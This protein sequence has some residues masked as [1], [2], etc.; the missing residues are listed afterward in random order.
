MVDE[1]T[2]LSG[3]D[4][5]APLAPRRVASLVPWVSESL[6]ELALADRLVAVTDDAAFPEGGFPFAERIGPSVL[7]DIERLLE[8][9]PDLV[10]LGPQHSSARRALQ[11][12]GVPVWLAAPH[13]VREAF[14]GLWDWMNAFEGPQMSARVRAIEWTCDWL[15]R[16]AETRPAPARVL[17]LLDRTSGAAAAGGSYAHDLLRVCGGDALF[18][19]FVA[20][21]VEPSEHDVIALQ[22]EVILLA[23]GG[24]V[25][26]TAGD[27][28]ALASLDTPAGRAGRVVLVDY[29]LLTWPGTRVARAFDVLPNLL[30]LN[31]QN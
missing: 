19:G 22:P 23:S 27:A 10:L 12:A 14:N 5:P 29:T 4:R 3:T 11:A 16:L 24:P 18:G 17:A 2:Y 21:T 25:G 28:P 31:A 26:F 20:E 9:G 8:L 1:P 7:P 15:E 30:D 6:A 13:T